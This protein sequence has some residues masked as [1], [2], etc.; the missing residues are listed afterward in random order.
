MNFFHGVVHV[1]G[2][3]MVFE[4]AAVDRGEMAQSSGDEFDAATGEAR[5]TGAGF[6]IPVPDHAKAGLAGYVGKHVV[7][8][9]RPEHFSLSDNGGAQLGVKLNVVEP[10]GND[11]DIYMATAHHSHVVGRVEA[12]AGLA[13]NTQ[14]TM[15]V[16]LRKIHFFEP[17]ETGRN[18]SL[19]NEKVHAVA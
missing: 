14:V 13:M 5:L 18:L 6:V 3:K 4:E 7:M 17:G 16:D 2:G 19:V 12:R 11:M 9:I 10:L 1:D 8:G 15:F